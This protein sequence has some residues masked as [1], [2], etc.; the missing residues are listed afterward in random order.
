MLS[1]LRNLVVPT[2]V[3]GSGRA[4]NGVFECFYS[5]LPRLL[6]TLLLSRS[7]RSSRMILVREGSRSF[8]LLPGAVMVAL[9]F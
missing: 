2:A 4:Q 1:D 7:P 3:Q 6:N 9:L 8:D 5:D